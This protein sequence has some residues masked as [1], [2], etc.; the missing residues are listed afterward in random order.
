[1]EAMCRSEGK[2]KES[3]KKKFSKGDIGGEGGEKETYSYRVETDRAILRARTS[4]PRS[5]V[6]ARRHSPQSLVRSHT[7]KSKVSLLHHH[8]LD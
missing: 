2:G 1:M 6:I 3:E 4:R 7:K 8:Y 5:D